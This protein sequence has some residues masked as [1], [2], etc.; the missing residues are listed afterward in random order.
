LGRYY[1]RSHAYLRCEEKGGDEGER[2]RAWNVGM[3]FA[4]VRFNEGKMK[5]E[6]MIPI[7]YSSWR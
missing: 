7:I 3:T 4:V 6:K 5:E 1:S 2:R